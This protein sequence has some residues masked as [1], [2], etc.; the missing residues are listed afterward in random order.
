MKVMNHSPYNPYKPE[1]MKD[2][3]LLLHVGNLGYLLTMGAQF[4]ATKDMTYL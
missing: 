3:D 1:W 4:A 2:Q